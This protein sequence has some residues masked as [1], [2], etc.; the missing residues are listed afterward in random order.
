MVRKASR[1][2]NDVQPRNVF[3]G[4]NRTYRT[5]KASGTSG[6]EAQP[7][8]LSM[9]NTNNPRIDI[10]YGDPARRSI[11]RSNAGGFDKVY[12]VDK[13]RPCQNPIKKGSWSTSPTLST[14]F[15]VPDRREKSGR[16]N[17][18]QNF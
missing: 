9:D 1:S 15:R 5:Y 12:K 10:V 7:E 11:G 16:K 3:C 2:N 18:N 8:F 17:D 14:F 13:V 6:R 4:K